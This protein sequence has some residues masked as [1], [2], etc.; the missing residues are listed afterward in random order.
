MSN[1]KADQFMKERNRRIHW[2]ELYSVICSLVNVVVGLYT[3]AMVW[4]AVRGL[5]RYYQM[6]ALLAGKF[7]QNTSQLAGIVRTVDL[8]SGLALAAGWMIMIFVSQH[9]FEK[10]Q[11]KGRL[12]SAVCKTY[13]TMC[14][15]LALALVSGLVFGGQIAGFSITL[16][17]VV[18]VIVGIGLWGIALVWGYRHRVA[19]GV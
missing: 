8:T 9:V 19:V 2:A 6:N 16:Q 17:I 14:L 13:G 18:G 1:Q 7:E 5:M 11:L 3:A 4:D 10:A 12:V 15:L